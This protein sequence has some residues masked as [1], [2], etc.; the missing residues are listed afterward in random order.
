MNFYVDKIHKNMAQ[1]ETWTHS[2]Q[3]GENEKCFGQKQRNIHW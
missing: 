2:N 3:H 1:S